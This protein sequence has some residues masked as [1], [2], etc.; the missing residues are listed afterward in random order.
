MIYIYI[1]FIVAVK[2]DGLIFNGIIWREKKSHSVFS[3][4]FVQVSKIN[5]LLFLSRTFEDTDLNA[6]IYFSHLDVFD[7][8]V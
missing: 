8:N 4:Y 3:F 6:I 7:D 5:E 1:K 2:K